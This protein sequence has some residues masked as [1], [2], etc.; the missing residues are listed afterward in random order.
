VGCVEADEDLSGCEAISALVERGVEDVHTAFDGAD[1]F[2]VAFGNLTVI[3]ID[4][5][6]QAENGKRGIIQT[7]CVLLWF[8]SFFLSG[9]GVVY[10]VLCDVQS[11]PI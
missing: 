10:H 6:K 9:E 1:A 4:S 2:D 8:S 3:T 11:R 5:Q 7:L